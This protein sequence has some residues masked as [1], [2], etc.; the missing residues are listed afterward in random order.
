[1]T[2]NS[3]LATFG[4]VE[5]VLG[6]GGAGPVKRVNTLHPSIHVFALPA[7]LL[8]ATARTRTAVAD[9]VA[10]ATEIGATVWDGVYTA[11][12]A[13]LG[14]A[15]YRD[16]SCARRLRLRQDCGEAS[17]HLVHDLLG[18]GFETFPVSGGEIQGA[19]L[20]ATDH[21]DRSGTRVVERDREAALTREVSTCS[22]RKD[23]RRPGQLV[24]AC[25]GYDHDRPCPPLFMASG[26]IEADE[27][28]LAA[29]HYNSSLPT[30][31]PS[32]HAR[33][34]SSAGAVS[35]HC[36]SSSSSE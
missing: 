10:P 25:G 2:M 34:S 16:G 14:A 36:A 9:Q 19:R 23:D 21:A 28:D 31:W 15:A 11:E 13:Q 1:M 17:Q 35:S 32:S 4:P 26:G 20:V 33:S 27:P 3:E 24:E 18:D 30:G 8:A 22:D 6:G 5:H 7:D 29:A 12:Q